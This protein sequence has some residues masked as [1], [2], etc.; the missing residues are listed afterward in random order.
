MWRLLTSLPI[1][2]F[3]DVVRVIEYYACR[4]QIEVY[5]RVFKTGCKVEEIQLEKA[6][7]LRPCLALY[8]IVA[9]RVL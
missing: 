7:R 4:W 1:D 6:E 8:E 2:R 5:F 9:W 3:A